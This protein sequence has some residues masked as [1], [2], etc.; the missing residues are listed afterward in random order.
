MTALKGNASRSD[1]PCYQ[2]GPSNPKRVVLVF[3]DVYGMQSGRH[4]VFCDVIQDKLGS[5]TSVWM[6]DLFRGKPILGAWNMGSWIT[7]TCAIPSVVWASMTHMTLRNLETDLLEVIKPAL[8]TPE[9]A[10]VGFCYG[11]WVV[12]RSIKLGEAL[13][14]KAGIGI[15]PSYQLEKIF[16]S[17]Q[18]ELVKHMGTTPLLL[19][20]ANNDDLKPGAAAVATLAQKRKI[21][22]DQLAVEFA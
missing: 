1:L 8:P 21:P 13:G 22:E 19:L 5:G 10:C 12:A 15:H 14:V 11:G 20:P 9:I 16:G 17:T 18:E 3:S 2:I 7:L 4:K 6:P